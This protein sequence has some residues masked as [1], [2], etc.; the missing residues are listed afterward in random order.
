MS[1]TTNCQPFNES[2]AT[3]L[4]SALH[5]GYLSATKS[6]GKFA[7]SPLKFEASLPCLNKSDIYLLKASK[8]LP[9]KE[10]DFFLSIDY[11][12]G[13]SGKLYL[14]LTAEELE[15]INHEAMSVKNLG[16]AFKADF[17]KELTNILSASIFDKV[18]LGLE[19]KIRIDTPKFSKK[20]KDTISEVIFDDFFGHADQL[21]FTSSM[22][23]FNE[24][25]KPVLIIVM[26]PSRT[27]LEILYELG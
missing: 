14:L 6:I 25:I 7:R 13:V 19:E 9:E 23:A 5:L 18:S 8:N 12:G 2:A 3:L 26:A 24:A 11:F 21:V 15:A 27:P 17:A 22:I 4:S 20:T 10:Y 1:K 16:L